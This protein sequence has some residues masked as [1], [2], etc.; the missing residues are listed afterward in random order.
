MWKMPKC[1]GK[2]RLH[3]GG[4]F[5]TAATGIWQPVWLEPV[6]AAH[7]TGLRMEPDIDAGVLRLNISAIGADGLTVLVEA[8]DGRKLIASVVGSIAAPIILPIPQPRLWSPDDPH[9]YDLRVTLQRAG[10]NADAVTS[11]FA[12]RKVSLG[13]DPQGRTRIFLNNR[14]LLEI[15]A[16]DQGYRRTAFTRRQRTRR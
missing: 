14:F 9:L 3:P 13:K 10:K 2:Q 15:G 1:W 4:I 7:I 5:Y 11:Y 12:M 8:R 6:P 16:L